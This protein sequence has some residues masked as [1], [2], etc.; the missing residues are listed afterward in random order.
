MVAEMVR[1]MRMM[2]MLVRRV[3][4]SVSMAVCMTVSVVQMVGR[5]QGVHC[6]PATVRRTGRR[7]TGAAATVH[8]TGAGQDDVATGLLH[9]SRLGT[10]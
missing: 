10:T 1:M 7:S 5:L 4:V 6:T 8:T 9:H 2:M 3:M